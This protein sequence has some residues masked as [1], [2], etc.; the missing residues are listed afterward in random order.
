ME[1]A[2]SRHSGERLERLDLLWLDTDIFSARGA[3]M[4][5][6]RDLFE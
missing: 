6:R 3:A 1:N 4:L 5:V 2:L